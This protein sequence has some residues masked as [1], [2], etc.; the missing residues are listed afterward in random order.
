M[1][2]STTTSALGPRVGVYGLAGHDGN[3]LLVRDHDTG[4]FRLPGRRVRSG[5]SVEDALRRSVLEQTNVD[6][7]Y[8]EF[9]AVVELHAPNSPHEPACYELALLFEVTLAEPDAVRSHDHEPRWHPETDLHHIALHPV[10]I[11][12][13][14]R[15]DVLTAEYPS[16][17]PHHT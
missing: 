7:A 14:L 3:L 12:E 13:H 16:W 8:L 1:M 6:L 15:S 5:E 11:A 17:W 10:A 4:S 2:T 9:C